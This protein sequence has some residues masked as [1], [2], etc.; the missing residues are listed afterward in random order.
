MKTASSLDPAQ[1]DN[2]CISLRGRACDERRKAAHGLD[3]ETSAPKCQRADPNMLQKR[4]EHHMQTTKKR[5]SLEP[6]AE[7]PP[8]NIA[9]EFILDMPQ[10]SSVTVAGSFNNWDI[11]Q[12]PLRKTGNGIWRASVTL[13]P[14]RYEHRF[15]VDGQW[16][17]D[18]KA[19]ESGPNSF[20]AENSVLMVEQPPI[21]FLSSTMD[22]SQNQVSPNRQLRARAAI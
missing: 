11:S 2:L 1:L 4:K 16:V 9:V 21:T 10:A 17:N 14:G 12:K 22:G 13:P 19:N 15:V 8:Q 18:P 7:K 5:S 20:G 3:Q 6:A